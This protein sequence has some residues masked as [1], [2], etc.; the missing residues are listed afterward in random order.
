[1]T[2]TEFPVQLG[3]SSSFFSSCV[4]TDTFALHSQAYV[5]RNFLKRKEALK[6]IMQQAE[7][8]KIKIETLRNGQKE[9]F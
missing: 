1:M 5:F 3:L 2:S 6:D 8:L 9:K 4:S 7:N